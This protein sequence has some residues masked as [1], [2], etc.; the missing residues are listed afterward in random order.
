MQHFFLIYLEFPMTIKLKIHARSLVRTCQKS[1][2][3]NVTDLFLLYIL[4]HSVSKFHFL[5]KNY[6]FLKSLKNGQFLFLCQKLS[7]SSGE[8]FKKIQFSRQNWSKIVISWFFWGQFSIKIAIFGLIVLV[9]TF[10]NLK[11]KNIF[12]FWRQNSN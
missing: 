8:I 12:R 9:D 3:R 6:K 11:F 5:F 7:I 1:P 2:N 4:Y 10:Q